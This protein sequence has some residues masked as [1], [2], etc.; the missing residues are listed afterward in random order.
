M[1]RRKLRN[2]CFLRDCGSYRLLLGVKRYEEQKSVDTLYWA[3]KVE[4]QA[5]FCF[6]LCDILLIQLEYI[7]NPQAVG[8]NIDLRM[9]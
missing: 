7:R 4:L 1:A 5:V 8:N 6:L 3:E 9:A 2:D